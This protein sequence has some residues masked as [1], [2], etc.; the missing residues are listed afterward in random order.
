MESLIPKKIISEK[1]TDNISLEEYQRDKNFVFI[2]DS[3]GCYSTYHRDNLLKWFSVPDYRLVQ[4]GKYLYKIPVLNKIISHQEAEKLCHDK[5]NFYKLYSDDKKIKETQCCKVCIVD[6]NGV[7]ISYKKN[8]KN[9]LPDIH[10]EKLDQINRDKE[11]KETEIKA[12]DVER[13]L[14]CLEKFNQNIQPCLQLNL[15]ISEEDQIDILN[16]ES[17]INSGDID[18]AEIKVQRISEKFNGQILLTNF[19]NVEIFSQ[20]LEIERKETEKLRI[21][22]NNVHYL[23]ILDQAIFNGYDLQ[24]VAQIFQT[25][26]K[27]QDYTHFEQLFF[28][29]FFNN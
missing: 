2:Y 5:Y 7:K 9:I 28:N 21:V 12:R 24:Q 20:V 4:E 26:K 16:L 25:N 22:N 18:A 11:E 6:E 14:I 19:D 3:D 23:R 15:N 17:E 8:S 27:I 29:K 1:Y 10:D 13:R